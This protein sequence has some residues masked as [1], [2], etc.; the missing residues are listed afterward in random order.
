MARR[1][2]LADR[3]VEDLR[4]RIAEGV[5]RPGDRLPTETA[6]VERFGVSRTVVREAIAALSADGHVEARQGSGVFVL[7]PRDA[8]L[9]LLV[10]EARDR[11]ATVL[12]VLELRTAIEVEA[13][14][15][16]ATRRSPAQ[17]G[18]MR[19]AFAAFEAAMRG[20]GGTAPADFAFH[21]SIAAA[22]NNPLFPQ[23][24]ETLGHRTIPRD[25]LAAVGG[26]TI[27][28]PAY[29]S[30]I[31]AEHAAILAAIAAGDPAAAA[32]AMRAHLSGSRERY[33]TLLQGHLA[34]RGRVQEAVGG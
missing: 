32:A 15:L 31:H 24:L 13:A 28:G 7:A 29:L 20:G 11:L 5:L 26:D 21:L 34:A 23:S 25:F 17:E 6:L 12:N 1:P 8:R 30:R 14:A 4:Q 9:T 33:Q 27:H 22:T 2:K 16:A 18:A 3:L 19:E 10:P